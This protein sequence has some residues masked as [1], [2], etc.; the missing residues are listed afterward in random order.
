MTDNTATLPPHYSSLFRSQLVSLVVVSLA[1]L[2]IPA[3]LDHLIESASTS[4]AL[5]SAATLSYLLAFAFF[6][7][8]GMLIAVR[9]SAPAQGDAARLSRLAV[10]LAVLVAAGIVLGCLIIFAVVNGLLTAQGDA[11][12]RSDAAHFFYHTPLM[13]S[14]LVIA[15]AAYIMTYKTDTAATEQKAIEGGINPA[16]QGAE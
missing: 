13:V 5:L 7:M 12:S 8:E 1:S 15:I 3:T 14:V 16:S 11:L 2:F 6:V 10:R 9:H 4:F